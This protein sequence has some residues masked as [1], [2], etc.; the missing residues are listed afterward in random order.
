MIWFNWFREQAAVSRFAVLRAEKEAGT[1]L[2]QLPFISSESGL[3][4]PPVSFMH[5]A[6]F[7]L[8][9][10]KEHNANQL[11]ASSDGADRHV[12]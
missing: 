7:I 4:I 2:V 1:F 3:C 8:P 9:K 11:R 5:C 12:I 6:I 10:Y